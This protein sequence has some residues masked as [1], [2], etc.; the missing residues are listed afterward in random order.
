MYNWVFN[1]EYRCWYILKHKSL[2]ILL[3]AF[4]AMNYLLLVFNTHCLYPTTEFPEV[5]INK[6]LISHC[7][8]SSK[9]KSNGVSPTLSI[10]IRYLR[11]LDSRLR[12]WLPWHTLKKLWR[13]SRHLSKFC[14]WALLNG[15]YL[16]NWRLS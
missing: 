13:F 4:N 10:K 12:S 15:M 9:F 8:L 16:S 6:I 11:L 2:Y 3:S 5:S 7:I 1:T 14:F